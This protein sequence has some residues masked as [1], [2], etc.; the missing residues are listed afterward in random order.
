MY[1]FKSSTTPSY[2]G[3]IINASELLLINVSTQR[4]TCKRDCLIYIPD[5]GGIRSEIGVDN[6]QGLLPIDLLVHGVN[7]LPG[8]HGRVHRLQGGRN[9]HG[10]HGLS[11]GR[12]LA[13]SGHVVEKGE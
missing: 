10:I 3:R 12:V 5:V 1:V 9:I 6:L 4:Q 11:H 7:L 2:G 13:K 8:Q